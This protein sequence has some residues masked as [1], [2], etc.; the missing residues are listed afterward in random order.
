[1][2]S[3]PGERELLASHYLT[4]IVGAPIDAGATTAA[5]VEHINAAV[6]AIGTRCVAIAGDDE[7]AVLLAEQRP[8]I[9][10]RLITAS[11]EPTLPRSLSDKVALGQLAQS[12][13]VPYPRFVVTKD[14]EELRA[15][16]REA[17]AP[18]VL[19]SPAPF[20]RLQDKAVSC[21]TV[22]HDLV[23]LRPWEVAAEAGHEIF[24]QE[25]LMGPGVQS[26]YGAGVRAPGNQRQPVWTGRKMLAHPPMTGIGVVNVAAPKPDLAEYVDALC[27]HV[28]WIG[29]FDTDWIVDPR[30]GVLYLIDFNPRRGAQFRTFQTSTDVDVVRAAHLVLTGR[31]V[32]WGEQ[33]FGLVHTVENLALLHGPKASPWRYRVGRHPIEFSWYARDDM[34]PARS[35]GSQMVGRVRR[36]V[37]TRFSGGR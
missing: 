28:G 14:P 22:V 1:V 11:N 34:A 13:G 15:F 9:D 21:T 19:K 16:A 18:L 30:S 4:G 31:R 10:S 3:H 17:G 23:A 32:P 26:W 29:P 7:S 5:Q 2:L 36:K 12:T 33:Q 35:L 6:A 37:P 8:S 25:Y 20:A 27:R 24:L